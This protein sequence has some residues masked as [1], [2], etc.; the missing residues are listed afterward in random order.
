MGRFNILIVDD[1]IH[2][3]N[4]FRFILLNDHEDKINEIFLAKNGEECLQILKDKSVDIVFMDKNMPVMDGV[5]ATKKAVDLYWGIKIIAVSFHSELND[6]KRMLEAGARNYI[7]KEE[8]N[9][10]VLGKCLVK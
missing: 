2:F 4:A 5:E 6:V 10:E 8:I 7:V 3:L 9:K 1:N